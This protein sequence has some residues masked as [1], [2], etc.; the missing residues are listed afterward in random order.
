MRG[1]TNTASLTPYRRVTDGKVTAEIDYLS[2]I[3]E[4]QY[5]IA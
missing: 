1:P 2:A 3:E 4:G 5:V